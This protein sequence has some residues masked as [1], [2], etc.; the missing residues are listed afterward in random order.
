MIVLWGLP[1]DGPLAAV[2]NVLQKWGAPVMFLDQRDVLQTEIEVCFGSHISGSIRAKD[3]LIELE[4]IT[5]V[6][7]RPY[8]SRK[9]P[10]VARAG[11]DSDIWQ[12]ALAVDELLT[13][14]SEVTPALVV[15]RP[16]AMATNCSK[17]YQATV[18]KSFG[19]E[20]PPTLITTDPEAALEFWRHYGT[21]IYKSVSDV[22]SIVSRLTVEQAARLE[23]VT[24]CPTQFQ[25]YIPGDDYRVHVVGEE[26]FACQILSEADDYRY[27]SQQGKCTSLQACELPEEVDLRCRALT[28]SLHLL[29]AGIDLRRT[30]DGTWYCFEVNPSPGFTYFQKGTHQAIDEAIARLLHALPALPCSSATKPISSNRLTA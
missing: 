11:P 10:L 3:Q 30:P 12:H 9:L 27:A 4:K 22:R 24:C 8:D 16:E 17:P 14:W 28:S 5:A 2:Y 26:V 18:I 25:Q 23:K 29:V 1:G 13:S 6:Y 21:V 19:F 20:I 15:N 7:L